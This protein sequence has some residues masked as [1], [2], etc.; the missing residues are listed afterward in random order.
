[1]SENNKASPNTPYDRGT[2]RK[3]PLMVS[4]EALCLS[5]LSMMYL[6]NHRDKRKIP[7]MVGHVKDICG[8]T[9][10]VLFK[11]WI[12]NNKTIEQYWADIVT[13]TLYLDTGECLS[14][15]KRKVVKW[16]RY[17]ES[18]WKKKQ[19]VGRTEAQD[20]WNDGI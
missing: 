2:D 9:R 17:R 13:G 14:S 11:L 7:K 19:V 6:N 3:S 15:E 8:T 16:A 1:M 12:H 5:E 4:D 20:L 10:R 18:E